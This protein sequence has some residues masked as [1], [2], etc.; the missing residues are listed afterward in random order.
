MIYVVSN[1]ATGYNIPWHTFETWLK[2][3]KEVQF[4]I[5]TNVTSFW[6]TKVLKLMQF[7]D[8]EGVDQYVIDPSAITSEQFQVIKEYLESWE[9]VKLIHNAAFEYIVMRFYGAEVHNVYCSMVTEKILQGGIENSDYSL[10]DLAFKY[11]NVNLDKTLQTSFGDGILT[12]EKIQYAVNDVKYLHTIRNRQMKLITNTNQLNVHWLEM[13]HLLA[14]SDCTFY[15]VDINEEQWLDNLNLSEPIMKHANETLNGW[16]TD[17]TRL[18]AKA[19]EL[20][21]Y[22]DKDTINFNL[23]SPAQKLVLLQLMLPEITGAGKAIIT[24]YIKD[25]PELSF[26]ELCILD[27]IRNQKYDTFIEYLLKEHRD[28]L[29]EKGLLLPA[30]HIEIN[31]NSQTQVLP[32]LQAVEPKLK[33]LS[34]EEVAK[35]SHPIF[36][37][38]AEYKDALKLVSSYGASFLEKYIE[39]DG[40]VRTN[41]NAIVSTGR[42]SSSRPNLQQVPARE[43]PRHIVDIWLKSHPGKTDSDC[44]NRYRNCFYSVNGWKFVDSDLVGQE[45]ALI[46]F[47]SKDDVW[48]TT[49]ERGEDL[50][51]VTAAKVFGKRWDAAAELG[52]DFVRNKQKCKCKGHKTFRNA[53]KVINFGLAYGMSKYKL[54]K[55]LVL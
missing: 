18:F 15:G 8:V 9:T 17:D 29:I 27:D 51:S 42:C 28:V 10:A 5:E 52:C 11:C 22:K 32:L 34:K 6:C 55:N 36:L 23:N 24:R 2:S 53:I 35:T 12:E 40:K 50:H 47:A 7:G 45:L 49:I 30:G 38:L 39:P 54:K 37:D 26:A 44:Y 31:W 43:I 20:G 13:R 3:K 14:S 46:A 41:Y 33:A 4:D 48:S 25:H 16:I 21:I 1:Q 19:I